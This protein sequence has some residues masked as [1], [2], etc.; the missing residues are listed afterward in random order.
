MIVDMGIRQRVLATTATAGPVVFTAVWLLLGFSHDGYSA[1]AETIS[2]LSAYDAPRWWVMA[3]GQ[4]VLAAGFV[5]CAALAAAALGRRGIAPA[6]F[7]TLAGFGTVQAT[8]ARTIC[9]STN[10][11]WCTPL[12]ST[13]HGWAQWLHG[14]GAGIAFTSL[15]LACLAM[16]W[17]TIGVP[18]LRDVCIFSVVAEAVALPHMLW[19]LNNV[20][21]D[22]H[23]L[24][25]KVFLIVLAGWVAYSGYRLARAKEFSRA[26]RPRSAWER[27]RAIDAAGSGRP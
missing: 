24:A 17:A 1:R 5:A 9:S 16:A 15:L 8:F 27:R 13:A 14:V 7:L 12:P 23:G 25:E 26:S 3:A 2:A 4:L 18:E 22:W 11:A 21:T 20:G 6:A 19:F 10:A